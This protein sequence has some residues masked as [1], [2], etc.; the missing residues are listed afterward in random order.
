MPTPITARASAGQTASRN[1]ESV[2]LETALEQDHRERHAADQVGGGEV[3]VLDAA[4]SILAG[5][6]A[7]HQ[8]HQQHRRADAAGQ[9]SGED[10]QHAERAAEQDQLVGELHVGAA[11]YQQVGSDGHADVDV[12]RSRKEGQCRGRH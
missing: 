3:V 2:R 8:E 12:P 4:R 11:E 10:A 5:Q 9:Q 6:H 1:I 7:E